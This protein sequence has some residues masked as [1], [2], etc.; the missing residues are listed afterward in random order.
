LIT[1]FP[2]EPEPH[3]VLAAMAVERGD[4]A[5]AADHAHRAV[6]LAQSE[7]HTLVQAAWWARRAESAVARRWTDEAKDLA[8]Q[9]DDFRL[10]EELLHLDG[11]LAWMEGRREEAILLL[12]RAFRAD[13]SAVGV[14]A[15][16]AEG[17]LELGRVDDARALLATAQRPR[18]DDERLR[19]LQAKLIDVFGPR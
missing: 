11:I 15:D 10:T 3:L 5:I 9:A 8:R 19:E 12:E 14:A 16:L 7:P 17:Y 6:A 4:D 18:P 13:P 1:R 2:N